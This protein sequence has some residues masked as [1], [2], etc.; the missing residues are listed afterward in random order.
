MNVFVTEPMS[1]RVSVRTGAP[2]AA[3]LTPYPCSSVTCPSVTT[4]TVMP[5]NLPSA[6]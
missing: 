6:R 3:L 2:V 5:G 4:A 1:N